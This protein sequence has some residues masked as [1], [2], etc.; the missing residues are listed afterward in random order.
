MLDKASTS[1][2]QV[3]KSSFAIDNVGRDQD[4][5]FIILFLFRT[6]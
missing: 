3:S 2:A 6:L 5:Q 4:Q 1:S